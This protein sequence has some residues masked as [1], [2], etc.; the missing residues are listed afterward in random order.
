MF[1]AIIS[2]FSIA[3]VIT[4]ASMIVGFVIGLFSLS[5]VLGFLTWPYFETRFIIPIYRKF[6]LKYPNDPVP[7]RIQKYLDSARTRGLIS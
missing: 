7:A 6:Y 2:A 3:V 5:I 4:V 1:E